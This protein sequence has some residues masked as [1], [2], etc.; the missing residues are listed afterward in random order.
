M[1]C[2]CKNKVAQIYRQ[3]T[4]P[5]S[6][7]NDTLLRVDETFVTFEK[8]KNCFLYVKLPPFNSDH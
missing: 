1:F 5:L 2:A 7:H 8:R 4:E 6:I 3:K